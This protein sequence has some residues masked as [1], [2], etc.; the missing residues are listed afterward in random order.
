MLKNITVI[1]VVSMLLLG[2][3]GCT[4]KIEVPI[5]TPT[6]TT[7]TDTTITLPPVNPSDGDVKTVPFNT[8]SDSDTEV[9]LMNQVWVSP[10]EV[11]IGN[12]YSGARAEWNIRLHNGNDAS[13]QIE[14]QSVVSGIDETSGE[15]KIKKPLANGDI[16]GVIIT[17][18]NRNDEL[19]V[20]SY[21]PKTKSL[22]IEGLLPDALRVIT[23][24]Y[25]AWTEFFVSYM[26]SDTI[27]EGCSIAPIK[28]KDWVIIEDSSPVLAPKETREIMIVL[29]IP[30]D[31]VV[32]DKTWEFWTVA[33][34]VS[35]EAVQTQLATR[36]L[37]NMR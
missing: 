13:P 5:Y 20:K 23:V 17:S 3:V 2:I 6:D 18:D 24:N 33:G 12:F 16:T 11:K 37:V 26:V 36:W 1:L 4:S 8:Q 14:M 21:D 19:V 27:R 28:A 32:P 30:Q 25:T 15:I 10:A 7:P 9:R 31:A 29:D 34:E 22:F 35:T